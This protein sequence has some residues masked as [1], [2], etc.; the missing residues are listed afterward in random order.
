MPHLK[1]ATCRIRVDTGGRPAD[2][3][4]DLCPGCGSLLQPVGGLAEVVGFRLIRFGDSPESD[5]AS[6]AGRRIA[7]QVGSLI[8]A[9]E[10]VDAQARSDAE[11][12]GDE[13]GS[14]G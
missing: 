7:A 10:R 11:H 2:L 3:D 1:C 6:G 8:A 13:G 12:W 5:D 9:H 4:D 14:I